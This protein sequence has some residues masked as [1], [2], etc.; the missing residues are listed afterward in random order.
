MAQLKC[1]VPYQIFAELLPFGKGLQACPWAMGHARSLF[2]ITD[3][4]FMVTL[5]VCFT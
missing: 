4:F 2:S 1:V 3:E 5:L